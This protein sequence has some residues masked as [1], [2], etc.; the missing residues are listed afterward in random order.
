MPSDDKYHPDYRPPGYDEKKD[1]IDA[2]V[3]TNASHKLHYLKAV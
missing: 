3:I 2:I 1:N